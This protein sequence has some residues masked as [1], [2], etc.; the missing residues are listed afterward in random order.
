MAALL[1]IAHAPLATALRAVGG[2][3]F[4]E[5]SL[6]AIDV[7]PGDDPDVV[8]ARAG[9]AVDRLAPQEV[10]V[11]TDVFGAS[12]CNGAQRLA[13][14]DGPGVKVLA[15]VSV[16]M[17][18]RALC[19]AREPLDDLVHRALEGG[20]QGAMLVT[21]TPPQNQALTA[22]SHDQDQARHQQ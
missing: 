22:V 13:R 8:A 17:L 2:H 6:E 12:P 11:L 4:P 21:V 18:W 14:A 1:I 9:E 20:R 10:L 5:V 7:G 15:G 3:A 16:P 19:Y